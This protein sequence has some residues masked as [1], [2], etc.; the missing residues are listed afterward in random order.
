MQQWVQQRR[1]RIRS[2]STWVNPADLFTKQLAIRRVSLLLGLMKVVTYQGEQ[3]FRCG[4][5][6]LYQELS[7]QEKRMTLKEAFQILRAESATICMPEVKR[8][9]RVMSLFTLPAVTLGQGSDESLKKQEAAD[10]DWSMWVFGMCFALSFFHSMYL[11]FSCVAWSFQKCRS[12]RVSNV[13]DETIVNEDDRMQTSAGSDHGGALFTEQGDVR[14]LDVGQP[15][16]V[17]ITRTGGFY[18]RRNCKWIAGRQVSEL[19]EQEAQKSGRGQ[20]RTCFGRTVAVDSSSS[21][22]A[23]PRSGRGRGSQLGK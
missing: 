1:V 13:Q 2:V 9:A 11:I 6:E 10:A 15:I 8:I 21:N 14:P 12:K 23:R 5:E 4:Q 17:Y 3:H 19:S 20:C 18:H 7:R 22:A 16:R